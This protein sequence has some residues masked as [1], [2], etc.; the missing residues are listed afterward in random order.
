MAPSYAII[1]MGDLKEVLSK[2]RD[3]KPLAWWRYINDIFVLWQHGKKKLER[4]L[5]FLNCNHPTIKF[6]AG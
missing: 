3:K 5:E 1:F 4:F 6:I 2:D